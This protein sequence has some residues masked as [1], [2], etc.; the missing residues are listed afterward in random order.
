[1]KIAITYEN[2]NIFGHFGH[3]EHFKFYE[4]QEG[5]ILSSEIVP[6]LGSGHGAL[7]AFL[8]EKGVEA[9]ICGGIGGGA[10]AALSEAGIKLYPGCSGE[11]D[12][13]AEAFAAGNLQFNPNAECASHSHEAGHSC[14][15]HDHDSH[16]CG[17]HCGH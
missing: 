9:L 8:K 4:I 11:A 13:Q 15:S 17:G 3:T 16:H 2:G 6:V 10:K 12:R 14:S 5:A 1:M 7:A